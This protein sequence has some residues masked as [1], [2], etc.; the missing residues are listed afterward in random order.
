MLPIS[1]VAQDATN[2][3]LSPLTMYI[4]ISNMPAEWCRNTTRS[5]TCIVSESARLRLSPRYHLS[6]TECI[7]A[8]EITAGR[9]RGAISTSLKFIS[10]PRGSLLPKN[11]RWRKRR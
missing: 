10:R 6:F 9:I 2:D 7:D 3:R 1:P 11:Q 8:A 4:T 5:I